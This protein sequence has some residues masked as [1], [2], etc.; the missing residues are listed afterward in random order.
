MM[1]RNPDCSRTDVD[2]I[3]IL[4]GGPKIGDAAAEVFS[5]IEAERKANFGRSAVE[6]LNPFAVGSGRP[7][8]AGRDCGDSL[9][10][11]EGMRPGMED[12]SGDEAVS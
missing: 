8:S 3:G 5:E 10:E 12:G 9:A 7:D 6:L 4:L 1:S 2:L 11:R